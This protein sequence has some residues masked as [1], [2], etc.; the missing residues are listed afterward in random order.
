MIMRHPILLTTLILYLLSIGT[1]YAFS[2]EV[3]D[4]LDIKAIKSIKFKQTDEEFRA[5]VVVQFS[6]SAK[7]AIKFRNANFL[8]TFKDDKDNEVYLGTTQSEE[9]FFPASEDGTEKLKEEN[10]AV[11]VGKNDLDTITRLI[12]IFNL[13]GNP[14]SEF[15]MILSGTTQVGTKARRGWIYQGRV[16]IEDFSF[17][18]TIQREVLFK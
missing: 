18:P 16:E 17:H 14:E 8:I 11:Y 10:L 13:I 1:A 5:D 3:V 7:S 6:T 2:L 15:T 4:Q 9:L 12:K